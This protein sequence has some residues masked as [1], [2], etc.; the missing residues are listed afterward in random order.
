MKLPKSRLQ[1]LA[2][3]CTSPRRSTL[4]Q[5]VHGCVTMQATA[6]H[7]SIYIYKLNESCLAFRLLLCSLQYLFNRV[8]ENGIKPYSLRYLGLFTLCEFLLFN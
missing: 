1:M 6:L 8:Y 5:S 7:V 3:S 2:P 4:T